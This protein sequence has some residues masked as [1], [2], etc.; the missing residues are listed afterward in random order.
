MSTDAD[1]GGGASNG[2]TLGFNSDFEDE[3]DTDSDDGSDDSDDATES[4][5]PI[6]SEDEDED[7]DEDDTDILDD[8]EDAAAATP[9]IRSVLINAVTIGAMAAVVVHAGLAWLS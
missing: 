8:F 2:N 3:L 6:L 5:G 7:E 9:K 1:E 4:V